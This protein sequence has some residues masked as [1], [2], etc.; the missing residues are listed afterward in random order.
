MLKIYKEPTYENDDMLIEISNFT[1]SDSEFDTIINSDSYIKLKVDKFKNKD[2]SF[3]GFE[4]FIEDRPSLRSVNPETKLVGSIYTYSILDRNGT[5]YEDALADVKQ[6]IN[7]NTKSRK[8][9]IRIANPIYEYKTSELN[10]RPDVS[11]LN[12]I[13]YYD[14]GVKLIFRASDIKNELFTDLITI[15]WFFIKP[16]F[17]KC[18]IK[19]YASTVQNINGIIDFEN[20]INNMEYNEKK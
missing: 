8:A 3:N 11:C 12:L 13:H 1:I 2:V 14:G 5:S 16:I 20:K 19:I 6:I 17:N 4:K 15:Y 7:E 9:V 10:G 18:N